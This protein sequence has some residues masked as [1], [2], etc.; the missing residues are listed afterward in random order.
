MGRS[1]I[2]TGEVNVGLS[3]GVITPSDPSGHPLARP[4]QIT[5]VNLMVNG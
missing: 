3:K 5:P 2:P 4:L 1:E